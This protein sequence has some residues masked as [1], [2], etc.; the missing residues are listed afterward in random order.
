MYRKNFSHRNLPTIQCF[1]IKNGHIVHF[2]LFIVGFNVEGHLQDKLVPVV[3][4]ATAGKECRS[5]TGI[6]VQLQTTQTKGCQ[7]TE[8]LRQSDLSTFPENMKQWLNLQRRGLLPKK[9]K[10][11]P[12]RKRRNS[13]SSTFSNVFVRRLR[14]TTPCVRSLLWKQE[15]IGPRA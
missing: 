4:C 6:S 13:N 12:P 1:V 7:V 15:R 11:F 9:C 10:T 3:N 5:L 14:H 2:S 8:K